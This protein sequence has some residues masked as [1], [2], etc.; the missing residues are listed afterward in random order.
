[1]INLLCSLF[2]LDTRISVGWHTLGRDHVTDVD[3]KQITFL[4]DEIDVKFHEEVFVWKRSTYKNLFNQCVKVYVIYA[5]DQTG[6][7]NIQNEA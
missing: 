3:E 1:M 7:N 4:F 6:L 5:D 2:I